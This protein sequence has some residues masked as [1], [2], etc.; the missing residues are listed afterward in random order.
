MEADRKK[1]EE[2]CKEAVKVSQ[3]TLWTILQENKNTEYG[4]KYGFSEIKDL[5]DY[6]KLPFTT[7]EDYED[8]IGRMMEG[9]ENILT[10]YPVKY[11]LL[12]SGSS[13]QKYIPMTDI[14]LTKGYDIIYNV[15]LPDEPEWEAARHLH[16][17]V[18]KVDETDKIT[19]LSCADFQTRREQKN[20][21]FDKFIG[22]EDFIFSKEM[23]DGWYVKLWLALSEP[24]MKSVYSIYLYDIL[25]FLQYFK[26]HWMEIVE[27]M[28]K[29]EIPEEIDLTKEIKEK[30]LAISRPSKEWF[31]YVRRECEKG[32]VGIVQRVWKECVMV[33]GIGGKVFGTQEQVL[34]EFL[35]NIPIHYYLY[36]SSEAHIGIA[37]TQEDDSYVC[38]PHSCFMEFI[39]IDEE[40]DK[41]KWIGQL[42]KGKMYELVITN[43]CGL[44]RYRMMDVV[45]VTGFYGQTPRIRFAFR[46]NLAVN[47]AGEKTN[48]S[49]IAQ[50]MVQAAQK[51]GASISE[52]SVCIDERVMPN[53][54][55]FFL[56]GEFSDHEE[57]YAVFFDQCLRNMHPDYD[58]LR[59]MQQIAPPV[60]MFVKDKTHALWKAKQGMRGHNKPLQFSQEKGFMEFME[61]GRK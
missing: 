16:T 61:K 34:R 21:F 37:I 43:F 44:Y 59:E 46:R 3:N 54:Y 39:P 1:F 23:K 38:I 11:Y 28:E 24:Q 9:E 48:L 6:K 47:I 30:L 27:H 18:M 10:A 51:F 20:G 17:S 57:T 12:S 33:S 40:E 5:Q 35:G 50:L 7:Y 42:E 58:E 41:V 15:A 2:E 32:F 36:A 55:C 8:D 29:G 22:G 45:E 13:K 14:G 19:I 53:R 4:Q 52:Y 56:E 49:M 60:C 31:S 26:E 25:L